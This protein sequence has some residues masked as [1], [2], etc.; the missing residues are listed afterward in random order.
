MLNK[1]LLF[2]VSAITL[3][4]A[5]FWLGPASAFQSSEEAPPGWVKKNGLDLDVRSAGRQAADELAASGNVITANE[6]NPVPGGSVDNQ[7]QLRGINV[8]VNDASLDNIQVFP[9]FR[10]FV[11]YTESETSIAA[12]GRNIVAAYNT[13]ANQPLVQTSPTQLVFTQRFLSGFSVSADGGETWSSGFF[14]P[15]TG[16]IFTFG[17]PVV[18]VDRNGNFYFSG[19]GATATGLPTI[20][21]N[22]S[23]DGGR[24]WS[25]AVLV[26]QDNGGDKDWLA[27]G[28]DPVVKSRDNV[29]VTWTSFQSTGAQL[30]LGRSIDG[31]ATWTTKT[32]YAPTTNP[33]PTYPTNSLQFSNTYVD[34]NT[35]VLYIPFLHFS[36]AN[37]DFI[38]ILISDDAGDTFRFATFNIPGAPDPTL[39]TEGCTWH[40]PTP[41]LC[42]LEIKTP[43]RTSCS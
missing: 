43:V 17:D 28:P 11:K 6:V 30:R 4:A 37:Q 40:G 8:Q 42:C 16:S 1:R 21:L 23:T 5:L 18:D 38:Q 41:R 14:P 32:I 22:K 36:R 9:N 10:P 29:Y 15:L 39:R 24:T 12:F 25:P 3:T 26:Q 27:V 19:L 20:Q 34:P 33:N 13:S 35:G 31:G 2:T 7:V